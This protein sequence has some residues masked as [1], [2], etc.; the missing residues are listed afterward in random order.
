MAWRHLNITSCCLS[1]HTNLVLDQE[2]GHQQIEQV[3]TSVFI[4][5][6]LPHCELGV[7][8]KFIR[9][10]ILRFHVGVYQAIRQEKV[11]TQGRLKLTHINFAVLNTYV[12]VKYLI[13]YQKQLFSGG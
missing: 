1:C 8:Y 11:Y 9:W 10:W 4:F 3:L 7:N 2:K 13:F 12:K 6:F 5:H